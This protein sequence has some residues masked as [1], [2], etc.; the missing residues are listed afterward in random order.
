MLTL[1]LPLVAPR[2]EA[3]TQGAALDFYESL[4]STGQSVEPLSMKSYAHLFYTQKPQNLAGIEPTW[5]VCR[6]NN[7][8]EWK[9]DPSKTVVDTAGAFVIYRRTSLQQQPRIP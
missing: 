8:D 1:F 4:R 6:I 7:I 2:I 5:Y 3:Y 9:A